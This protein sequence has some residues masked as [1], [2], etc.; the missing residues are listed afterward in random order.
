M[1]KLLIT[2]YQIVL[3]PAQLKIYSDRNCM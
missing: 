2:C 3:T 1:D